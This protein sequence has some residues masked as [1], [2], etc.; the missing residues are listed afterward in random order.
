MKEENK[1]DNL[2]SLVVISRKP[3]KQNKLQPMKQNK[4][5]PRRLKHIQITSLH[6]QNLIL[7]K[8][9]QAEFVHMQEQ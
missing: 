2:L 5:Q 8:E 3:M 6:P 7:Q 4:L 9:F 1:G